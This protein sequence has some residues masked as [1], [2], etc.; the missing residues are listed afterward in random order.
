MEKLTPQLVKEHYM[1]E[2]NYT[3]TLC[4]STRF[5]NDFSQVNLWLT[6]M[7]CSVYSVSSFPQVEA[8]VF[9]R[10]Q[11][12]LLDRVHKNKIFCSHAIFVIDVNGYIGESTRS[13]IEYAKSEGCKVYYLTNHMEEYQQWLSDISKQIVPSLTNKVLEEME[14]A[15]I[16]GYGTSIIEGLDVTWIAKRGDGFP[17]W[18]IYFS[19]TGSI[20]GLITGRQFWIAQNGLKVKDKRIIRELVPNGDEEFYNA[21]R[22]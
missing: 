19:H 3:V 13:E 1:R 10:E 17:D 5:K 2:D 11:K 22:F 20:S 18:A 9:S 6:L 4:G 7:G 8:M 16:F 21:Y 14:P 15:Q 12:E